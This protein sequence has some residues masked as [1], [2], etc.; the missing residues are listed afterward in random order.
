[1]TDKK[2]ACG[3][4]RISRRDFLTVASA[5]AGSLALGACGAG[6]ESDSAQPGG[7]PG[8][9]PRPA[10]SPAP[11]P[12]PAPAPSPIPGPAPAPVPT[13]APPPPAPAPKRYTTDFPS[14][15]KPL[16]EGGLWS[17]RGRHW[18]PVQTAN[19]MAYG[20]NGTANTYD[21]SYAYLSGFA[22]D[23][24]CEAVIYRSPT[25][26]GNPHESEL[27]LRW[28]DTADI[29]R[30]YECQFN[31]AGGVQVVRW[32]GPF[33]DFT[34][35]PGSGSIGR[36]LKTGDVVRARIV[37]STITCYVNDVQVARVADSTWSAGQPGIGF[38]KRLEGANTDLAF[39]RFTATS[40]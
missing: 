13:P 3:W 22:A 36:T 17:N 27:L 24:E 40:L 19:G 2:H 33:G 28:T 39:S 20:T 38:F 18:T 1:M 4:G 9:S 16:S 26:S 8:P 6:A 29:A 5:A 14:T 25:L 34:P 15:E 7:T 35:L 37:G 30:G 23:Q 11:I 32:N 31:H 21:D 12:T 10:P